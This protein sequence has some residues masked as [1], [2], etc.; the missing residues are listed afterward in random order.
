LALIASI[1]GNNKKAKAAT[2]IK[3]PEAR[4]KHIIAES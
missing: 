2:S 1:E 3:N 4:I